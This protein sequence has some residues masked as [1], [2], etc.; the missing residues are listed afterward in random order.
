M[1]RALANLASR[2]SSL[3]C[4]GE[5][6]MAGRPAASLAASAASNASSDSTSAPAM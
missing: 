5:T 4:A 6:A 3:P 1:R 2:L